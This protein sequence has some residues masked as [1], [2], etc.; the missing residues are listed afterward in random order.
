MI[1]FI[2]R[3]HDGFH[4]FPYSFA[5]GEAERTLATLSDFDNTVTSSK[6]ATE[7]AL[8]RVQNIDQILNE[9]ESTVRDIQVKWRR[10]K[11]LKTVARAVNQSKEAER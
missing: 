6:R 2:G 7:A 5:T 10:A 9:V 1:I 8:L 4:R 3:Y 11:V